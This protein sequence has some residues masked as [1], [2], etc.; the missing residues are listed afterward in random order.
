MLDVFRFESA[1][2]VHPNCIGGM[3]LAQEMLVLSL[4][5]AC[6]LAG[7]LAFA[8]SSLPAAAPPANALANPKS[9]SGP[10]RAIPSPA[11]LDTL[12]LPTSAQ[13]TRSK[14]QWSPLIAAGVSSPSQSPTGKDASDRYSSRSIQPKL[15][16]RNHMA[17][18]MPNSRSPTASSP[19]L[20]MSTTEIGRSSGDWSRPVGMLARIMLTVSSLVYAMVCTT[21]VELFNCRLP[22]DLADA[23]ESSAIAAGAVVLS[24]DQGAVAAN[25]S[26]IENASRNGTISQTASDPSA[27]AVVLAAYGHS[28]DNTHVLL[29]ASDPAIVCYENTSHLVAIGLAICAALVVIICLPV[30]LLAWIVP[31]IDRTVEASDTKGALVRAR[32][33]FR[34]AAERDFR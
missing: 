31:E 9:R 28:P 16:A 26:A 18:I 1:A 10:P 20:L 33:Q 29:L 11:S 23:S 4:S 8:M 17:A 19:Q 25:S 32:M 12:D 2:L 22:R 6:A 5:I 30:V 7:Y 34:D 27:E 15:L 14:M 21:T 24:E 3:Q 13:G